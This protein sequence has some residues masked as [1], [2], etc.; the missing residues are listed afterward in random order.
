MTTKRELINSTLAGR[1]QLETLLAKIPA[2][3]LS[4]PNAIG[5]WSIKDLLAHLAIWASRTVTLLFQAERGQAPGLLTR[6]AITRL[7]K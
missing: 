3:R 2:E 5:I 6:G 1:A 4:T 7:A